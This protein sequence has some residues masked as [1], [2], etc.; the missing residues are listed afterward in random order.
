M[1]L[2]YF[3]YVLGTRRA[4]GW[5]TY[6]GWTTDI[7]SRLERHNKGEGAKSTRGRQWTILYAERHPTRHDAMSRE[8][9]LK[10]DKAF[11]KSLW[12]H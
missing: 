6:V 1:K 4:P 9:H 2:S 3:V 12:A 8:W 11:R 5:H 10:R 7:D